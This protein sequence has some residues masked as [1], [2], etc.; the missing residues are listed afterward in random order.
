MPTLRQRLKRPETYLV[1]LAAIA[2]LALVDV[3]RPPDR[4]VTASGYV[5]AVRMYQHVGRP[6]V[7]RVVTC[8]YRPTCS[9]YSIDAVKKHGLQRGLRLTLARLTSCTRAVPIG[10]YSP[11]P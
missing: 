2:L 11:V 6:I 7:S 10:T 3:M 4:Q 1:A 9:E 5:V 8:R